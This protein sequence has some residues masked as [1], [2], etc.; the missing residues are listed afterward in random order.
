M[1]Y[2]SPYPR[3]IHLDAYKFEVIYNGFTIRVNDFNSG[4]MYYIEFF[5]NYI[6]CDKV[7][8]NT[9]GAIRAAKIET[10]NITEKMH[11][12]TITSNIL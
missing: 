8:K 12:R 11:E 2:K 9:G 10:H 5:G 4:S 7:Y 1:A 3:S 6:V